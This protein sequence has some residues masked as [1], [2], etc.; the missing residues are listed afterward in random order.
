MEGGN[1]F[2]TNEEQEN[3]DLHMYCTTTYILQTTGITPEHY[4]LQNNTELE[5][6]LT[7]TIIEASNIIDN[8]INN[9]TIDHENIP[10][11]VQLVCKEIVKNI[12][13]AT[14]ARKNIQYIEPHDWSIQTIPT[15]IFPDHLKELLQPYTK[16]DERYNNAEIDIIAITGQDLHHPHHHCM[17]GQ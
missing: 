3:N 6:I 15:Q 5:E 8:Y 9:N 11:V 4:N 14:E 17:R 1:H 10:P 16:Q 2:L 12:M 13:A 7:E